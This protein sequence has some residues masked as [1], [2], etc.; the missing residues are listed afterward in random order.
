[1][2]AVNNRRPV[3]V[4]PSF[5]QCRRQWTSIKTTLGQRLVPA[6]SRRFSIQLESGERVSAELDKDL[7]CGSPARQHLLVLA[8]TMM[9]TSLL[10]ANI[11]R[12]PNVQ[13]R[14]FDHHTIR[15]TKS[16]HVQYT[17]KTYIMFIKVYLVKHELFGIRT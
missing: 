14:V 12:Q 17:R 9:T 11:K 13:P 2:S 10:S 8:M 5:T 6:G 16:P 4:C 15:S 3:Q 7:A 1:M